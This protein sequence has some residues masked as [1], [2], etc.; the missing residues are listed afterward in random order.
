MKEVKFFEAFDK[1]NPLTGEVGRWRGTATI[2]TI[3]KLGLAA[4]LS[5]PLWADE[6]MATCGLFTGAGAGGPVGIAEITRFS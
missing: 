4:D 6:G 5:H 1:C 2:E 3:A